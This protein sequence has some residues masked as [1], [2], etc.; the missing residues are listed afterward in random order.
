[1]LMLGSQWSSLVTFC[2]Q[3]CQPMQQPKVLRRSGRVPW[4]GNG[5]A[6]GCQQSLSLEGNVV[7]AVP[8]EL[9]GF[10]ELYRST[11]W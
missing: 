10:L 1:M 4:V 3:R 5:G 8:S 11:A 2:S 7:V 9:Q 6:H